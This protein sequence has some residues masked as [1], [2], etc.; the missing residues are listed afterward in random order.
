MAYIRIKHSINDPLLKD[1]SMPRHVYDDNYYIGTLF[2]YIGTAP[3]H[4]RWVFGST[5]K[6]IKNKSPNRD[7]ILISVQRKWIDICEK[8][9]RG[10]ND[11]I[12]V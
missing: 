12:V 8:V 11:K 3:P 2:D 10:K 7:G 4:S 9:I 6:G 5:I 1:S